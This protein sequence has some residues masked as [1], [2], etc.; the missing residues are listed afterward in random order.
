MRSRP[1]L[2]DGAA[3]GSIT[4]PLSNNAPMNSAATP[5]ALRLPLGACFNCGQTGHFARDCPNRNQARKP[6]TVPEPEGVE[7][8]T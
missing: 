6:A 3:S 8:R 7:R 5:P 2:Q 4:P 1:L